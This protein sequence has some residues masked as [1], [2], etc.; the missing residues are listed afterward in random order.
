MG[1]VGVDVGEV[2]GDGSVM[3]L[4]S[5]FGSLPMRVSRSGRFEGV[6]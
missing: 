2:G 3:C 1:D 5:G 4:W 6:V